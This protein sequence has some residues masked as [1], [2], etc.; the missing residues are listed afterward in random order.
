MPG[1]DF[2]LVYSF[3]HLHFMIYASKSITNQ[4][5]FFISYKLCDFIA[6]IKQAMFYHE[7]P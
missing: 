4:K 5:C 3:L 6:N 2:V 1:R 7:K